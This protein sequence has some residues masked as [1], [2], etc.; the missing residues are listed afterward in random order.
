MKKKFK[1]RNGARINDKQANE[2]GNHIFK[3]W[4]SISEKVVNA[5][6]VVED[7]KDKKAP[8]HNYFCWDNKKAGNEHRLEQARKLLGSFVEVE[9]IKEDNVDKEIEVRSFHCV[10]YE[11]NKGYAPKEFVMSH[12]EM[13]KQVIDRA[14]REAKAWTC[15][16][17]DYVKLNKIK[18][19][20]EEV[21]EELGRE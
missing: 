18:D 12:K 5:E 13:A 15:R 3:M 16:Y 8:Y 10:T 11:G 7:A 4:K 20:I 1:A 19:A 14:L 9:I 21:I 2:Y 17:N 6:Q